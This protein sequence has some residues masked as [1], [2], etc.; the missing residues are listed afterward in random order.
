MESSGGKNLKPRYEPGYERRYLS[1]P[2]EPEW[3]AARKLY[4]NVPTASSWGPAQFMYR[5]AWELGYRGAPEGLNDP[6]VSRMLFQKKFNRDY[7]KTG[8]SLE[9]ALLR[10]NGGGNLEYPQKV[11]RYLP[12]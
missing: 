8:N 12:Q 10:Y 7:Q 2:L 1:K 4:G 5:T 3:E 11:R 6:E 9:K